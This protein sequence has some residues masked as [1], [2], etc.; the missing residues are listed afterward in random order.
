M[1]DPKTIRIEEL[2]AE[3]E[4]LKKQFARAAESWAETL[5]QHAAERDNLKT[6]IATT[7]KS[8]PPEES[9]EHKLYELLG[10]PAAEQ[11]ALPEECGIV[12]RLRLILDYVKDP[13]E[14]A[15]DV[16][17]ILPQTLMRIEQ[18]RLEALS[19]A[20]PDKVQ[21]MMEF[22]V[23]AFDYVAC[24]FESLFSPER[25]ERYT[26][27]TPDLARELRLAKKIVSL[28]NRKNQQIE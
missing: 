14:S 21:G 23:K 27:Y 3:N 6:Q 7:Q 17:K 4:K 16:K 13:H 18:H 8:V 25:L 2:T 11:L 26:P 28:K 9:L 15:E 24:W 10:I 20:M 19:T 5:K 12:D 1:N 22:Q